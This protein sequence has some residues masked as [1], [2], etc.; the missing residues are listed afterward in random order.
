[1]KNKLFA[2]WVLSVFIFLSSCESLSSPAQANVASND[3]TVNSNAMH[4]NAPHDNATQ[5]SIVKD[6]LAELNRVR[7]NPK[8]YAEE[9][10]KPRLKYFDGK[11]YKAPGQIPIL[12]N[13]G[14]SAVKECMDALM[15]TKPMELLEL[16]KGLCYSAQWLADDQAETGQAGHYGS[17]G[18][19]PFDRMN[20]YGKVLITAGE[21]C[22]YGPKTGREIVAQLLIDDGVADRGHRINILKKEFKKAGIGYNDKGKAPYGAVSVMDFAGDYVSK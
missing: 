9:E 7:R 10:I 5:S 16:E 19:S 2:L 6:I 1:M 18:S 22:A 8:K 20:R 11:L 4:D 3:N 13:E 14:A 15:K 21:N 12:T 17:D